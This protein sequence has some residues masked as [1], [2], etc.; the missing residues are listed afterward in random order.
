MAAAAQADRH[1]IKVT[2]KNSTDDCRAS[3]PVVSMTSTQSIISKV[4]GRRQ[5]AFGFPPIPREFSPLLVNVSASPLAWALSSSSLT[6]RST[7]PG[8]SSSS[9]PSFLALVTSVL[10]CFTCSTES[11]RSASSRPSSVRE[12]LN[13]DIEEI[14]RINEEFYMAKACFFRKILFKNVTLQGNLEDLMRVP[15]YLAGL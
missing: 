1:I 14:L 9:S 6:V 2:F 8:L 12:Y 3:Y 11:S 10:A 13:E 7:T 4:P 5:S 15:V